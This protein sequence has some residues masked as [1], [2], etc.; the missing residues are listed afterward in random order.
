MLYYSMLSHITLCACVREL[1]RQLSHIPVYALHH[2][3]NFLPRAMGSGLAMYNGVSQQFLQALHIYSTDTFVNKTHFTLKLIIK[4]PM[5][6]K[7]L[8]G[9]KQK[10]VCQIG[11]S[12]INGRVSIFYDCNPLKH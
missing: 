3:E 7:H 10:K 5:V 2:N 9:A 8:S 4:Y 1:L 6:R 11:L 12:L